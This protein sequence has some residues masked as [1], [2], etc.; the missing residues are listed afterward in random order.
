MRQTGIVVEM[1]KAAHPGVRFTVKGIAS[2]G[3]R[4]PEEPIENL[5]IGAF[6]KELQVALLRGDIDLAVHSL[7]D[8]P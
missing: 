8:L 2:A 4:Q 3:D 6:V 1:L 7:K 5:G